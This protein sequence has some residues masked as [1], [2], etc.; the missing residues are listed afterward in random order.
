LRFRTR[1]C[2]LGEAPIT[3][4]AS[5]PNYGSGSCACAAAEDVLSA[6]GYPQEAERWRSRQSGILTIDPQTPYPSMVDLA[7]RRGSATLYTVTATR[8][9]SPVQPQPPGRGDL[10]AAYAGYS[11]VKGRRV[12]RPNNEAIHAIAFSA[13]YRSGD[14]WV[15]T[16]TSRIN[17]GLIPRADF[18]AGLA[19]RRRQGVDRAAAGP[20]YSDRISIPF[21]EDAFR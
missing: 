1:R 8:H 15:L 17:C 14:A 10:L 20:L 19:A 6:N 5:Y 12:P 13:S 21:F 3:P 2:G 4:R 11:P 18:L 16:T 7:E 9:F